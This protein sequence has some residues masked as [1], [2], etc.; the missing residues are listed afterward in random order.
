[1]SAVLVAERALESQVAVLGSMLIDPDVVGP[2]LHQLTAEDFIKG[3]YRNIF[4]A[5][6]RL[7]A[8]GKTPDPFMVNDA[9]G[10]N[11]RDILAQIIELTPT[12]ANAE[13][14]A[15]ILRRRARQYHLAELGE[16]LAEAAAQDL[17]EAQAV[18]DRI[19]ALSCEKPGV[20]VTDLRQCY[21]AFLDRHAEGKKPPYFTW[22]IPVLDDLIYVEPGDFIVLGGYPSAGKTALALQM[23]FH[24]AEKKRV[25]Y[26][27]Y[28]NNDKKLFDRLVALKAKVSFGKIKRYDLQ[29]EDFEQIVAVQNALTAPALEFVDAS[30]MTAADVRALAL[31]RHYEL[32]VVDY[33]QKI[34][35]SRGRRGL[36]DF[37][38]VSEVSGDLQDLGRQTGV[39][40]LASS[41][42]SRP[43]KGTKSFPSMHSFRQSGQIEQDAD[44]ALLLFRE[45]EDDPA[46]Q[47]RTF[48][49]GKNKEGE[50]G[51]SL[52]MDFD[53]RTQTFSRV[54][55]KESGVK[56]TAAHFSAEGRKAQ[57]RNRNSWDPGQMEIEELEGE[58][59][60]LPF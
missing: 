55:P 33:L 56:D 5:F 13:E 11:Y 17:D 1:M 12:S 20:R 6:K 31:S 22:G 49:I 10:G 3:R 39:T 29:E 16:K 26:F 36:S 58:H 51:I 41:Q 45:A 42:L 9:L 21:E 60:D 54:F 57:A 23:C 15:A 53:G 4:L 50:A 19:S 7:Q 27:Y 25:G 47:V 35:G 46:N 44:V 24:I 48:K 2:M 37:E 40:V 52:S 14:Y 59:K 38:R 18:A 32:V 30:G 28:E 34:P 43:D 8:Q